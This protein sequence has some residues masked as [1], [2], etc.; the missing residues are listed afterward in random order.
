MLRCSARDADESLN[1]QPFS[2]RP[3]ALGVPVSTNRACV[4]KSV[5]V[6][7]VD[8]GRVLGLWN[9]QC[10]QTTNPSA[11]MRRCSVIALQRC[12]VRRWYCTG[13]AQIHDNESGNECR[14]QRAKHGAMSVMMMNGR[15]VQRCRWIMLC[16]YALCVAVTEAGAGRS[17]VRGRWVVWHAAVPAVRAMLAALDSTS[18]LKARARQRKGGARGAAE[19]RACCA[20]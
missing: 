8:C 17:P 18:R 7:W 15:R 3:P 10:Q 14:L 4:S 1:L 13:K 6:P 16:C 9:P 5:R 19:R 2:Y 20:G 12:A 11:T